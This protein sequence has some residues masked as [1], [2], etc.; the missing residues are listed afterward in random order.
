MCA[1][2]PEANDRGIEGNP[3][4]PN[5][6]LGTCRGTMPG[7]VHLSLSPMMVYPGAGCPGLRRET[8]KPLDGV[9]GH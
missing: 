9:L 5:R 6:V 7:W 4:A 2:M 3:Q 8:P 1:C